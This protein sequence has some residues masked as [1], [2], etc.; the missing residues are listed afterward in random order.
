MKTADAATLAT[1]NTQGDVKIQ[2]CD[3]YTITPRNGPVL[4][5]TDADKEIKNSGNTFLSGPLMQRSKTKQSV[6]INVDTMQLTIISDGT[7]L[8]SGK[9]I[10]QQ[11]MNGYF[12]GATIKVQKLFLDSFDDTSRAPVDWFEGFA[13]SPA[14]DHMSATLEVRAVT[15]ILNKQMPEDIY[16]PTCN[17]QLFDSVCGAS[18]PAFTFT[19]TASSVV[20]RRKFTLSG[21]VQP[22]GYF[23]LGKAKFTTGANAGQPPR[24]IKSFVGGVVEVFNPFP[25]E[26]ANGDTLVVVAGCDKLYASGNGCVKFARQASGF[27]GTPAVPVPETAVEGGGVSGAPVYTGSTGSGVVGSVATAGRQGGSYSP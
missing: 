4:R 8:V 18:E 10:I 25:Y 17:N 15:A 1:L 26:V 3:L 23:A 27:Q 9:S 21:V 24:T 22:N 20:D 6:G 12:K 13:G 2:R 5:L 16:Q 14:C 11:F 19:G 7:F